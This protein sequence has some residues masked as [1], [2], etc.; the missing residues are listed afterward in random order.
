MIAA[1]SKTGNNTSQTALFLPFLVILLIS[2]I[3]SCNKLS[4]DSVFRGRTMG[5]TYR[6][7]ISV[8]DSETIPDYSKTN[9]HNRIQAELD[10]F[11]N[12]LSE[13]KKRSEISRFNR[14]YSI[15]PFRVSDDSKLIIQEAIRITYLTRG[16]FDPTVG[17]LVEL[18]G[19]GIKER[20][21]YPSKKDI[22][23]TINIH[24]IRNLSLKGNFL[25][26]KHPVFR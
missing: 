11:E 22:Q 7:V 24:N 19:F 25:Q 4:G 3:S 12:T 21:S 8:K 18:W 16:A 20:K 2:F 26:K 10:R 17:R 1:N 13:W 6:I 23:E 14:F 9:I 15:K 5:T